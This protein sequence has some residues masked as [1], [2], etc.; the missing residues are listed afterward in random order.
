MNARGGHKVFESASSNLIVLIIS[1]GEFAGVRL[2]IEFTDI[3]DDDIRRGF[4]RDD[5]EPVL[6]VLGGRGVILVVDKNVSERDSAGKDAEDSESVSIFVVPT[7][8][9]TGAADVR[10]NEIV[11]GEDIARVGETSRV[12]IEDELGSVLE[13]DDGAIREGATGR[14]ATGREPAP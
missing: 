6:G 7:R 3:R 11:A 13:L 8:L 4:R 10:V 1:E 14:E 9:M 2:F 5:I 12:D